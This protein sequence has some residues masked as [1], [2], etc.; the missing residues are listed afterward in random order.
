MKKRISELEEIIN[1]NDQLYWSGNPQI[2]D[3]EY[4][5]YVEE[6][7]KLDPNNEL[8]NRVNENIVSSIGKVNHIT[9]MLSI[10]KIYEFD[11][12]VDWINKKSRNDDECF[13]IQPKYDGISAHLEKGILSTRGN[14]YVGENI[15]NKLSIINIETKSDNIDN[16]L[17]EILIRKDDFENIFSKIVSP[18]TKK[19]YKI[20][21]NATAGIMGTDDITHFQNQNA[22]LTFVDYN[23]I[24]FKV[25]KSEFED[26][27]DDIFNQIIKLPYPMDGIVI[28]L[29]DKE[30]G[31]SLGATAHHPRNA[32]ALKFGNPQANTTILD[33]EWSFGK[34]CLTPVAIL[35]PVNINGI[36]IQRASLS[37]YDNIVNM[38]IMIGDDVIIER[39]GDV[40]PHI[41]AV[42]YNNNNSERKNP[43]IT[44][45]P[46]CNSELKLVS[47]EIICPNEYCF[48]KIVRRLLF[49]IRT[50]GIE[51]VGVP[52]IKK[53]IEKGNV[54]NLI[55]FMNIKF[56]D[57][58]EIGFGEKTS[59][60]IIEEI[61][62]HRTIE[63]YQFLTALNIPDF[64]TEVAKL[65]LNR[66]DFLTILNIKD[67]SMLT[68]IKG[69]GEITANK[70]I[71]Y[72]SNNR[73]Y[74]DDLRKCFY[75]I[76]SVQNDKN[77]TVCFTGAMEQPRKYYEDI[78]REKHLTPVS[79]VTGNLTYLVVADINSTSS[80]TNKAKKYGIKIISVED[81]LNL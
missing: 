72:I 64:G 16:L 43:F 61:D 33:I 11:S 80:K 67:S 81:F 58:I 75:I 66:Y 32:V 57:L 39:A 23:L 36:T 17:G 76:T 14:G 47:P 56:T 8:V 28:K 13:V 24:S 63:A 70:I 54:K 41:V 10:D 73:Q 49:S 52:T 4:D 6:L 35:K 71:D 69:I 20:P 53:I 30:Y 15:S 42:I 68:S 3:E 9:P 37:N 62:K 38:N 50:I 27:W 60:N 59:S 44:K 25:K 78:A 77:Q 79:S 55:D 74:I 45:C 12:L 51:K 22:K 5:L 46:C 21:R 1:K 19:C 18:S 2:S 7:K 26:K 31:E 29:E 34:N 48:E 40:I 65:V